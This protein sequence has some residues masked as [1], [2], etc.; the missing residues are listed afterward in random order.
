MYKLVLSRCLD[1]SRYDSKLSENGKIVDVGY[2][3][4][5]ALVTIATDFTPFF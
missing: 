3:L 5:Y 4:I 2:I 1:F